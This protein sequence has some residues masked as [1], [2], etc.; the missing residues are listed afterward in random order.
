M[1]PLRMVGIASNVAFVTYGVLFGSIPTVV[2][3]TV[4]L[5][6]N[7]YRLYEMLRLIKQVEAASKG[8]M[9]LDWL[10]PFMTERAINAG[11]T[12]FRKGDQANHLYF[13]VG[14]RLH[15]D[16][17]FDNIKRLESALRARDQ[18]VLTLRKAVA[19]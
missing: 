19:G 6:L 17:M 2:L 11:D 15:L 3:H 4:L 14:G 5:P 9:S 12:L 16:E 7:I 8:D 10:K 13:V 1:I 18:E